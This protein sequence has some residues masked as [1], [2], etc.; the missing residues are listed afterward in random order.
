M[1]ETHNKF[2]RDLMA[3]AERKIRAAIEDH[4]P[5]RAATEIFAAYAQ[6]GKSEERNAFVSVLASRLAVSEHL[7]A[8]S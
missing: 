4:S 8:P 5:G 2:E 1:L 6:L 7:R 3:D